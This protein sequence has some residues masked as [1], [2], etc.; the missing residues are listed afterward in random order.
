MLHFLTKTEQISLAP[1]VNNENMELFDKLHNNDLIRM[2]DSLLDKLRDKQI[3]YPQNKIVVGAHSDSINQN[4]LS[5][6]F[7]KS[8]QKGQVEMAKWF[9]SLSQMHQKTLDIHHLEL[10]S[11][12]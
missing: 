2:E 6:L 3:T 12:R 10:R 5:S 8:C 1:L 7:L 11:R 9:Y 4:T